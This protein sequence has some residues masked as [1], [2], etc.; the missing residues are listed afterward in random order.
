[1]TFVVKLRVKCMNNLRV[2]NYFLVSLKEDKQ[3]SSN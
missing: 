1:L 2:N 3:I